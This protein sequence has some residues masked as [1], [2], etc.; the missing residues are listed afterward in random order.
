MGNGVG[1][2]AGVEALDGVVAR[3]H[4]AVMSDT[5]CTCSILRRQLD[6]AHAEIADLHETLRLQEGRLDAIGAMTEYVN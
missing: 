5:N 2:S 4:G 1:C 3:A 6:L